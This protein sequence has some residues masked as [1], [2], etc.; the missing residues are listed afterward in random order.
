MQIE[1]S[2]HEIKIWRSPTYF[3]ILWEAALQLTRKS[4]KKQHTGFPM[5]KLQID[6]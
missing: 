4:G 5:L 1:I 3:Q 6:W 2:L